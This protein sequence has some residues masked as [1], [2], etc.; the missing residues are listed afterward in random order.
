[1]NYLVISS[2]LS[3]HSKS[4]ILALETAESLR[5]SNEAVEFVDLSVLDVPF[6]DAAQCYTSPDVLMLTAKIQAADGIVLATPIYNYTLGSSA[7]NLIELTGEA[8][9]EKVVAFLCAAG[10]AHSYMSVMGVAS[11][12]MLD[13]RSV[14]V[15][16][17][18][19][20]TGDAF[21]DEKLVDQQVRDRVWVLVADLARMTSCLRGV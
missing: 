15:P 12:L 6:C 21:E 16:R 2:S 11:S 3:P 7:K 10:G 14:I 19:Y 17:F 4:R 9:T 1:M 13:F 5:A 20:A 18:V 8:W